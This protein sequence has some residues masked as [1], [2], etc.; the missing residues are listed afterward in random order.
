MIAVVARNARYGTLTAQLVKEYMICHGIS[1]VVFPGVLTSYVQAG[2]LGIYKSFKDKISP[3]IAAWK[4]SDQVKKAPYE[5]LKPPAKEVVCEWRQVEPVVID[6]SM[7]AAG[8]S[9][10]IEWM[11]WKYDVYG[12]NFQLLWCYHEITEPNETELLQQ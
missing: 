7:R 11:V 2:D 9:D 5:K 6:K 10:C 3:I 4:N 12:S 8:F 1:Y